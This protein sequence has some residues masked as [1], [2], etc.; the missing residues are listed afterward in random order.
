MTE[1]PIYMRF[2]DSLQSC[3]QKMAQNHVG[4]IIVKDKSDM[5]GLIT[6]QDIVRKVIAQGMNPLEKKVGD[7]MESKLVTVKPDT[8]IF[9]ALVKMRDMNI[10]HLPVVD[11]KKLI[12]LLTLKD[13]LKIEPQLFELLVE[14]FELREEERKPLHRQSEEE[15]ICQAC[16]EYTEALK[17][18]DGVLVCSACFKY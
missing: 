9:D 7:F 16:G 17:S 2:D 3:A 11:G 5:K 13:I 8:D 14:K 6:E 1:K 4:A 18:K 15:G 12:G 10:R